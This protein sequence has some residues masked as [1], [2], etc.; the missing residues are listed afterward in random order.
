M[1]YRV[2]LIEF[3]GGTGVPYK[4]LHPADCDRP[5][6]CYYDFAASHARL[7]QFPKPPGR[8][9]CQINWSNMLEVGGRVPERFDVL[10]TVEKPWT[11]NDLR[12]WVA[13]RDHIPDDYPVTAHVPERSR[14]WAHTGGQLYTNVLCG[15]QVDDPKDFE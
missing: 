5:D 2:H 14:G 6:D 10:A 4:I 9:H 3:T 7:D 1:S 15:L 12:E 13:V 11:M 8:Y